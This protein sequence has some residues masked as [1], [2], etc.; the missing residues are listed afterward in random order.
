MPTVLPA[1]MV[2][3]LPWTLGI[4]KEQPEVGWHILEDEEAIF[5]FFVVDDH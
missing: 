1:V 4:A 3:T 5:N 2:V